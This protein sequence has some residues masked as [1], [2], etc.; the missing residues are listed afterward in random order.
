[1]QSHVIHHMK[2]SLRVPDMENAFPM[3]QRVKECLGK[4]WDEQLTAI[5][6]KY[7][8]AD[9]FLQIPRLQI[10]LDPLPAHQWEKHFK[11]RFMEALDLALSTYSYDAPGH[12]SPGE[13][14]TGEYQEED[15]PWGPCS[16]SEQYQ[17]IWLFFMQH[18]MLPWWAQ[19]ETATELEHK[20][21]AAVKAQPQFCKEQW[22]RA[23][24]KGH[25]S[26]QRWVQQCSPALQHAVLEAL[27]AQAVAGTVVGWEATMLLQFSSENSA[28]NL[29]H[30][31]CLYWD[32]IFY[33]LLTEEQEMIAPA[34]IVPLLK[35]YWGKWMHVEPGKTELEILE[36]IVF[37]KRDSENKTGKTVR[38][39]GTD[40]TAAD[41][42][43]ISD[44]PAAI[45][46]SHAPATD[47]AKTNKPASLDL[48]IGEHLLI[49][50]AGLVLLHPYLLY[51]FK[52]F[53][54]LEENDTRINPVYVHRAVHLLA[55]IVSGEEQT[56]EYNLVF[57]KLLCGLPLDMPIEKE[58]YLTAAE[59]QEA[60]GLLEA[61]IKHWDALGSTSAD[62]L[63]STF[64]Q[65][66]GK[67]I[68]EEDQW[69]LIVTVQTVDILLSRLPWGFGFV[70][71]PWMQQLLKV[72]WNP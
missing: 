61:V 14:V 22:T 46:K 53:K 4:E 51:L 56:P 64:L 45:Q 13:Q 27:T 11:E 72:Q 12:H 60:L 26:V 36:M 71:L 42:M 66:E 3:Q 8:T 44:V 70:K 16:A 9:Q 68:F 50:D 57:P 37:R 40:K 62:G 5:L 30:L 21:I 69:L 43:A 18:G 24:L 2:V 17:D 31:Q 41:D 55:F 47:K 63:R 23:W 32:V 6:D 65:R 52:E 67:L 48:G 10:K 25:L 38:T 28:V 58:V 49:R 33:L 7:S 19:A 35:K 34:A 29:R 54:W 1:M 15:R 20:V 59:K 39:I